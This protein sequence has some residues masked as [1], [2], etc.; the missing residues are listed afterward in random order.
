MNGVKNLFQG[1][2][3]AV[4]PLGEELT[5]YVRMEDSEIIISSSKK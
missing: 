3:I 4:E 2:I 1:E 5:F